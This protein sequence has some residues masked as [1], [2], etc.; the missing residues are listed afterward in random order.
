MLSFTTAGHYRCTQSITFANA[1]TAATEGLTLLSQDSSEVW[2]IDL[3]QLAEVDSATLAVLI[4]WCRLAKQ[5]S[6]TLKFSH[7][8]DRLSAL[9]QVSDVEELFA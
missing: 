9:A 3:S 1:N 7:T 8:P 4:S 6:K 5:Q 2:E